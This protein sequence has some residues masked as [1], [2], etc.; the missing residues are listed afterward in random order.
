MSRT[1]DPSVDG[2]TESVFRDYVLD[3]RIIERYPEDADGP[4]YY[5]EAPQHT[6][7][8]FED[9]DL[10]E[11]YADVYFDVNGFQEEGTGTRGVPPEI[12]QAGKDTVAAYFLT[13]PGTDVNWVS[14]F[15]GVKPAKVE[16]YKSWVH[17]RAA[18]I[19]RGARERGME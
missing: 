16:R 15:Y 4:R 3:V 2:R 13:M 5:F 1:N 8:V 14:S 19:R 12:I 18:E 11:L 17:E 6:E 9:A 10:A 7:V